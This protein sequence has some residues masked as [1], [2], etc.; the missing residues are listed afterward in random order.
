MRAAAC[1]LGIDLI[2]RPPDT[3]WRETRTPIRGQNRRAS[4]GQ[5]DQHQAKQERTAPKHRQ[6]VSH[7]SAIAG[8]KYLATAVETRLTTRLSARRESSER[9]GSAVPLVL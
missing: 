4:A 6:P 2:H 1:V 9:T 5:N 8:C 7:A 3:R